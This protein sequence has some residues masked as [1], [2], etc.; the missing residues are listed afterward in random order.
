MRLSA[1]G[2]LCSPSNLAG[3]S[4]AEETPSE[5]LWPLPS[6]WSCSPEQAEHSEKGSSPGAGNGMRLWKAAP[7][8][9]RRHLWPGQTH[10]APGCTGLHSL[11]Q[12]S[13]ACPG[14][15]LPPHFS[16]LSGAPLPPFCRRLPPRIFYHIN[17]S[18]LFL[19]FMVPGASTSPHCLGPT[20]A[21][22]RPH[23]DSV[24]PPPHQFLSSTSLEKVTQDHVIPS[25][26]NL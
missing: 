8:D 15:T 10:P 12:G 11:T 3:A 21:T 14:P 5:L 23:L 25:R 20:S 19:S 13:T 7:G 4:S 22:T 16:T 26:E 18:H 24:I 9:K 6:Y 2:P 17:L 1:A